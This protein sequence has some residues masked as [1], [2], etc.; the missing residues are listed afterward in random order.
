MKRRNARDQK[1]L[2]LATDRDVVYSTSHD[3]FSKQQMI[4]KS[5]KS[6][7]D[8][9]DEIQKIVLEN[10]KTTSVG[11]HVESSAEEEKKTEMAHV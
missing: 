4:S 8:E 7:I 1:L 9:Y 5:I 10:R 6:N 3:Q 2:Q 11:S